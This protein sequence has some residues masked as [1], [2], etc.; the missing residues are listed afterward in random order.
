M[1]T[2]KAAQNAVSATTCEL[3]WNSVCVHRTVWSCVRELKR[4]KS[5]ISIDDRSTVRQSRTI[6]RFNQRH[7]LKPSRYT[8]L[9]H[10]CCCSIFTQLALKQ[11]QCL[12]NQRWFSSHRRSA[13]TCNTAITFT[14]IVINNANIVINN[15][16]AITEKGDCCIMNH[17]IFCARQH[18]C[19]SALF[20]NARPSVCLSVCVSCCLSHGWIS[21][22][23]LQLESRNLHHRVAP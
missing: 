2:Y 13:V 1:Y 9:V 17:P 21:Q 10:V 5:P 19:Y 6:Q 11:Q 12:Q 14:K 20:A 3:R 16:L 18:I 7:G 4:A 8:F 23:W 22:R 15:A